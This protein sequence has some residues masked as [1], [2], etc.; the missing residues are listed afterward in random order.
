MPLFSSFIKRTENKRTQIEYLTAFAIGC[1]NE[2]Q[3]AALASEYKE[4]IMRHKLSGVVLYALSGMSTERYKLLAPIL[5]LD[6]P[7]KINTGHVHLWRCMT[8]EYD[9]LLVPRYGADADLRYAVS[10][11]N[12]KYYLDYLTDH[13][14][15]SPFPADFGAAFLTGNVEIVALLTQKD[16]LL[17]DDFFISWGPGALAMKM[18]HLFISNIKPKNTS[19][20]CT[21][22]FWSSDQRDAVKALI[23]LGCHCDEKIRLALQQTPKGTAGLIT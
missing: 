21:L 15:V 3:G 1:R 2:V 4:T 5:G 8:A 13:P 19:V 23:Q 14:S 12:T 10:A 6:L 18:V 11:G 7:R 16:P 9:S 20:I 17:F 22:P